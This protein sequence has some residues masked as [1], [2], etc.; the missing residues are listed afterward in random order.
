[1]NFLM[2]RVLALV[3]K[4]GYL[5]QNLIFFRASMYVV[6]LIIV[7]TERYVELL[8]LPVMRTSSSRLVIT[9]IQTYCLICQ[10]FGHFMVPL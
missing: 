4:H 5:R 3:C 2:P 9:N 8:N 7:W 10:Q 6:L 1:M